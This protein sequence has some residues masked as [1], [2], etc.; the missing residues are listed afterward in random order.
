MA[1][2]TPEELSRKNDARISEGYEWD[3]ALSIS[4]AGVVL[5][6]GNDIWVYDMEG[7]QHYNPAGMRID[8]SGIRA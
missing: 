7:G 4:Y 3:K 2:L 5:R 6:K 1:M 8:V